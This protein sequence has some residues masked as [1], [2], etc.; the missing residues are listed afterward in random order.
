[1]LTQSIFFSL[2]ISLSFSQ[3]PNSGPTFGFSETAGCLWADA[4]EDHRFDTLEQARA[5]CR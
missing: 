2:F 4:D 3:C 5:R 1:M